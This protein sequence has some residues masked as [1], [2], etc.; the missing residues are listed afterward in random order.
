VDC[1]LKG[2]VR[3]LQRAG[4]GRLALTTHPPSFLR[5]TDANAEDTRNTWIAH[6]KQDAELKK[7]LDDPASGGMADKKIADVH[8][9]CKRASYHFYNDLSETDKK[10]VV[11][12]NQA[13]IKETGSSLPNESE[14]CCL[15]HTVAV[16]HDGLR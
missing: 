12:L 14:L 5:A 1:V 9:R 2:A 11:A 13:L 7:Q 16:L 15:R 10:V 4:K 8:G 6:R 3:L